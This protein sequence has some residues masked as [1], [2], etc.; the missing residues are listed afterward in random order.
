MTGCLGIMKSLTCHNLKITIDDMKLLMDADCLIKIA[1][2]GLKEMVCSHYDVIIP[3]TVK[4]ETVDQGKA[5]GCND[6][7]IIE[8]NLSDGKITAAKE[9]K[10]YHKG[11][12]ALIDV[13]QKDL[14]DAVATDDTKLI[15]RLK[16]HGIPFVLPALC[17]FKLY[18]NSVLSKDDAQRGLGQLAPFISPDE[19][20]AT[21]VLLE[22]H[23]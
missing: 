2:A 10:R 21:M 15:R 19:Y 23:P 20:A 1:K 8:K 16:I 7:D 9:H 4:V 12:D 22:G 14:H 3:E 17:L 18:K 5:K 11:D 6:A 13:F